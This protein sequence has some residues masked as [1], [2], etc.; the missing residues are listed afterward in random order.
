MP[1]MDGR[2]KPDHAKYGKSATPIHPP[3]LH[4]AGIEWAGLN[5]GRQHHRSILQ[6]EAEPSAARP[7]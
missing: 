4:H 3:L 6:C 1:V 5:R 7:V 2:E